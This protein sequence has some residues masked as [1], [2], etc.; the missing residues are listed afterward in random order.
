MERKDNPKMS[1]VQI[2]EVCR[3]SI[4]LLQN[5]SIA[6]FALASILLIISVILFFALDVRKLIGDIT[7]SNARKAI[8]TIRQQNEES[9][10]KAYKPSH[11]NR[12]RGRVTD[13][14][15]LSGRL[16]KPV[17][18][19][20]GAVGTEE[21]TMRET[22][23]ISNETTVL[24]GMSEVGEGTTLLISEMGYLGETTLLLEKNM[25]SLDVD[26]NFIGSTELIE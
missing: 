22:E 6:C 8:E 15:T 23:Y 26:M 24:T 12:A 10:D 17:G 9:G 3:M 19:M 16:E 20:T 5:L 13:K 25:F 11:V 4:E 7:G 2:R 21:L 14:I 1:Q 18:N